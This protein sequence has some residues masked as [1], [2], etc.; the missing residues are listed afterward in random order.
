MSCSSVTLRD[1]CEASLIITPAGCN[2]KDYKELRRTCED[3]SIRIGN[4]IKVALQS[5]TPCAIAMEKNAEYFPLTQDLYKNRT[6]S[7]LYCISSK[8]FDIIPIIKN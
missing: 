3:N 6:V 7:L 1:Q 5:M 2:T 4:R 8:H